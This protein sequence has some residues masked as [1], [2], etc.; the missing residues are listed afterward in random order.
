MD[1]YET[2][3]TS[4]ILPAAPGSS[5]G[6]IPLDV[7][8]RV[9]DHV[10]MALLDRYWYY[11]D[12]DPMLWTL[13]ACALVCRDWYHLSWYYL[14]RH[15][16]LGDR[17]AVLWLRKTLNE[18]PRL[19]NSVRQLTVAGNGVLD[20]ARGPITHLGA[21]AAMLV[22]KVPNVTELAIVNATWTVGATRVD[23]F[24]Y[25]AAFRSV[26]ILTLLDVTLSRTSQLALLVSALPLLDTLVCWGVD[27]AHRDRQA[28]GPIRLPLRCAYLDELE[29]F[30]NEPEV[31]EFLIRLSSTCT[32]RDLS[33]KS[34]SQSIQPSGVGRSQKMLDA[35]VESLE[36]A[37]IH[38]HPGLPFASHA[39]GVVGKYI[40]FPARLKLSA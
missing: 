12:S 25:F 10:A 9:I 36:T 4:P 30:W 13:H 40:I 23:D 2:T 24:I 17:E 16:L 32:I 39:K 5:P 3:A 34:Y 27:C 38:I 15:I 22:G 37:K 33:I 7:C 35:C 18:R 26:T 8:E 20:E 14:R 29:S 21:V 19:R 31:E 1:S 28:V 6:R 11:R